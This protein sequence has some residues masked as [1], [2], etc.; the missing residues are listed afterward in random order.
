MNQKILQTIAGFILLSIVIYSGAVQKTRQISSTGQSNHT[1]KLEPPGSTSEQIWK[2]NNLSPALTDMSELSVLK[3]SLIL[4]D[5][6]VEITLYGNKLS[7]KNGLINATNEMKRLEN[8][9]NRHNENS[10]AG[11]IEKFKNTRQEPWTVMPPPEYVSLLHK[12]REISTSS[13]GAFNPTIAPLIDLWNFAEATNPVVPPDTSI[14]E[15]LKISSWDYI[16]IDSSKEQV[17]FL[18][19]EV[20]VDCGGSGKGYIV[21]KAI[22]IL[23]NSGVTA[24]LINGGGDLRTFGFKPGKKEFRIGIQ[25]P[26]QKD[27]FAGILKIH[28]CAV[29]TSGDYERG[30]TVDGHYYHHLLDPQTGYPAR[31]SRSCTVVSTNALSADAYATAIFVRGPEKGIE[32]AED[33]DSIEAMVI[34]SDLTMVFSS[35]FEKYIEQ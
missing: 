25:N 6:L 2:R 17:S 20:S 27:G 31:L 12:S 10:F 3:E 26:D 32:L 4:M 16:D 24:A 22:E 29:A 7:I 1:N 9:F 34:T 35:G 19:R 13:K 11:K 8:I 5:T 30:F 15:K 28:N 33:I 21:D 23:K 14:Q 18:Q